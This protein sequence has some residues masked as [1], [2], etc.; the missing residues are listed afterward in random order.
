M[1]RDVR[2]LIADDEPFIAYDIAAAVEE[3]QGVV[4]G[5][6]GSVREIFEAL[7]ASE[8]PAAA[9][10]D[11]NLSDGEVTPAAEH[12]LAREVHVVFHTGLELPTVLR[13]RHPGLVVCKKPTQPEKLVDKLRETILARGKT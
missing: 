4:V 8:L 3:A 5:P 6:Y 7:S 2:V 9:I 13:D 1:L 12:L 10:L 11:V